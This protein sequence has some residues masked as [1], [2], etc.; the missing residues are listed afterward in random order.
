M[1]RR[2][3]PNK[4]SSD[5]LRSGWS[6][7]RPSFATALHPHQAALVCPLLSF[8]C[9]F[10]NVMKSLLGESE[11]IMARVQTGYSFTLKHQPRDTKND[12]TPGFACLR[13]LSLNKT[14]RS[15]REQ[16]DTA[17]NKGFFH[18]H[19]FIQRLTIRRVF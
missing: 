12:I 8:S 18:R 3:L 4:T 10:L 6:Q 16:G 11:V 19:L 7:Q 9:G 13:R 2:A 14:D 5:D 17:K 1:T 15:Y